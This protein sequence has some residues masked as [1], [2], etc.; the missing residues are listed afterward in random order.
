MFKFPNMIGIEIPFNLD[1]DVRENLRLIIKSRVSELLGD[2]RFASLLYSDLFRPLN[3][4]TRDDIRTNLANAIEAYEKR[5]KIMSIDI[6]EIDEK[7]K[8]K[9]VIKLQ[10]IE[11]Q[12]VMTFSVIRDFDNEQT[13]VY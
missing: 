4:L 8:V 11:T 7:R 1:T 12:S 3:P 6:S 9:V 13:L 2:P 5:V 10:V